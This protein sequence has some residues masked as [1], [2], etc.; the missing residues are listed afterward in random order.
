[1]TSASLNDKTNTTRCG[2]SIIACMSIE[3][4]YEAL[5]SR[6]RSADLRDHNMVHRLAANLRSHIPDDLTRLPPNGLSTLQIKAL[7]ELFYVYDY[8]GNFALAK[9]QVE[10]G[11]RFLDE[12][13]QRDRLSI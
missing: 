5:K 2:S 1:M 8:Y 10:L 12:L 3:H 6:V 9:R 13:E 7:V 11:E 4:A